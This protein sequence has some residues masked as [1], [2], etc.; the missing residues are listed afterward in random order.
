VYLNLRAVAVV[1]L[2]AYSILGAAE[3]SSLRLQT[4]SQLD[5]K[6]AAYYWISSPVANTSQLLTLFCRGCVPGT[7]GWEDL[8]LVS[9]LRDALGDHSSENDRVTY[10]WLLSSSRL[11]VGQK[12]LSAVP[13]FYWRVGDGSKSVSSRD[14]TPLINLNAPQHPV[15]SGISRNLVQWT[16]FDPLAKGVRATSRSFWANQV[17]YERLHLEAAISHLHKAPV[18]SD[19]SALTS[20]ELNTVIAR[21]ELRKSTLGGL[22]N[23]SHAARFGEENSYIDERIRSRNWEILRQFAEKT[24]LYFEG[25][26]LAGAQDQ[27][28][29][30]WFP[31]GGSRP[32]GGI[33]LKPIWKILNIKDPWT[34]HRLNHQRQLSYLR[35]VDENGVLLP[36][37][38]EGSKQ[39]RLVP[40][41]VYSLNYPKQ[42]LLLVDF[43]DKLR[44]RRHEMAQRSINEITA[45]V[46]GISHFANWY[47]YVGAMAYNMLWSRRGIAVDQDARLDCY[48]Q[49]RAELAL[50]HQLHPT[51]R[52]E[53]QSRAE[54]LA[55]NPLAASAAREIETARAHF[56]QLQSQSGESGKLVARLQKERRAELANFGESTKS[57]VAHN[58]LHMGTLG[59]Y[60]HRVK[61]EQA[62]FAALDG[63]RRLR[64]HLGFLDSVVKNGTEPE[65]AFDRLQIAS[66]IIQL[67]DLMPSINSSQ[68]KAHAV[69]TLE[70]LKSLSHDEIVQTD[71]A[72]AIIAL[73]QSE[74]PARAL[75]G[76]VVAGSTRAGDLVPP[77]TAKGAASLK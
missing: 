54:S 69:A 22:V 43:R 16:A 36:E 10:V 66:A 46:I 2:C 50:D 74:E 60:T 35:A 5:K 17:D 53:L 48:S 68:I 9:V 67:R 70:R 40:L 73:R 24:G 15:L 38:E 28:A 14:L 23:D 77:S 63:E 52:Q 18:S 3:N 29:I 72:V 65:V 51:L 30:L 25:M 57:S 42:P 64:Y 62:T 71:C 6:K 45:G 39:I 21:L 27:H 1:L 32:T 76:P 8:P 56:A 33:S 19:S 58:V 11:G 49:F 20:Q 31:V 4:T 47:Y 13:F 34:D 55:V 61:P 41:S 75:S 12:I 37:G 44:V 26:S 59:M 7:D